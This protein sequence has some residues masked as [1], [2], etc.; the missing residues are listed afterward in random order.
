MPLVHIYLFS[1]SDKVR[2][3]EG[4]EAEHGGPDE[5]KAEDRWSDVSIKGGRDLSKP[6]QDTT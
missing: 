1:P 3:R 5:A 2:V 4:G 6:I